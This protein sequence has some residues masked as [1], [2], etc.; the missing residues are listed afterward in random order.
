VA[1]RLRVESFDAL[2]TSPAGRTVETA[3]IIAREVHLTPVVVDGLREIDLGVLEGRHMEP[4]SGAP[5]STWQKLRSLLFMSL[6]NLTTESDA[7][8]QRRMVAAL[9]WIAGQHP[10]G[11]VV[12]VTHGGTHGI[13]LRWLFPNDPRFQVFWVPFATCGITEIEWNAD[14]PRRLLQLNQTEHLKVAEPSAQKPKN[15]P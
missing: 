8:V 6:F 9:D 11:H 7:A 13:L 3:E 10:T 4:L 5:Q 15:H 12:A 14:G 1:Q 2:Y